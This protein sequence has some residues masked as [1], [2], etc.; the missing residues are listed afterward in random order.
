MFNIKF[1]DVV[2]QVNEQMLQISLK[3]V[4][5]CHIGCGFKFENIALKTLPFLVE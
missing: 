3:Q 5:L 1:K 4:D 2:S